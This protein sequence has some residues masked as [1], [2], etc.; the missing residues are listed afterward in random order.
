[1]ININKINMIRQFLFHVKIQNLHIY[2]NRERVQLF[3][4]H[5]AEAS[6]YQQVCRELGRKISLNEVN[7]GSAHPLYLSFGCCYAIKIMGW[8]SEPNAAAP[9]LYM[10][11]W[12]ACLKHHYLLNTSSHIFTKNIKQWKGI[13]F[14]LFKLLEGDQEPLSCEE[15]I[16]I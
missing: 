3:P 7:P 15:Q 16:A 2:L 12:G 9:L 10:V 8:G 11:D 6:S 1:M 13:N 14:S 4:F 5:F